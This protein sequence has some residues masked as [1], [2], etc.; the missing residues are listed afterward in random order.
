MNDLHFLNGHCRFKGRL[1][2]FV[3]GK[4]SELFVILMAYLINLLFFSWVNNY[5]ICEK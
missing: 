2:I 5:I 3:S 1:L 4:L